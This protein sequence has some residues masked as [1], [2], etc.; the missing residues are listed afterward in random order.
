MLS[1][2]GHDK[3][4]EKENDT[5]W[6]NWAHVENAKFRYEQA[7]GRHLLEQSDGADEDS[8]LYSIAHAAWDCLAVLQKILD[9]DDET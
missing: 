6:D 5:K 9:K 8:G 7:I 3:Y 4:G 1:K 2:H